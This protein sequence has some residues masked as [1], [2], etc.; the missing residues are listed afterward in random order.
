MLLKLHILRG[1]PRKGPAKEALSVEI[2][3]AAGPRWALLNVGSQ[4]PA[5]AWKKEREK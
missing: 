2:T 1:I 4:E 5:L 3:P